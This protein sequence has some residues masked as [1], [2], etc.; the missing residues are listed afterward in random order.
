MQVPSVGE[1]GLWESATNTVLPKSLRL[2][3]GVDA[4][5]AEVS[6]EEPFSSSITLVLVDSRLPAPEETGDKLPFGVFELLEPSVSEPITDNTDFGDWFSASEID[7]FGDGDFVE[8][9]PI[10]ISLLSGCTS[11]R[12]Y[13]CTGFRFGLGGGISIGSTE[14]VLLPSW[15]RETYHEAKQKIKNS[16]MNESI[17]ILQRIH[18]LGQN[19]LKTDEYTSDSY[20]Y[21][22]TQY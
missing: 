19:F 11:F 7:K 1:D 9:S 10:E 18:A 16:I 2:C 12:G 22:G 8:H 6:L 5:L 4:S 14:Q 21:Y 17:N 20:R 3:V 15:S 13:G